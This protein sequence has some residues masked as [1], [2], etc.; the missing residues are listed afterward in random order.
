MESL[1]KMLGYQL[2]I[3]DIKGCHNDSLR[4]TSDKKV[5]IMATLSF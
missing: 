2:V 1:G 3:G 4:V 5:I